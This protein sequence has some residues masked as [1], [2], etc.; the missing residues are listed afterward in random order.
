MLGFDF[1]ISTRAIS[2]IPIRVL[3]VEDGAC[4]DIRHDLEFD[5]RARA[6]LEFDLESEH[7]LEF[8]LRVRAEGCNG[9]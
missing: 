5:L 7:T 4:L 9:C 3:S 1:G 6:R 2:D 8:D